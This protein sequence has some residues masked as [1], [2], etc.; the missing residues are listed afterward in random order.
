MKLSP[1]DLNSLCELA[2]KAALSAGSII[3]DASV[4]EIKIHSKI[5]GENIASQVVTE[6][7]IAA[8]DAIVKILK[9]TLKEF[10]LG[11]LTEESEDDNSRFSHDYFWCIDP[12]DGTLAFSQHL[13]GYST[14]IA[15]VSNE[16]KSTI[17]VVY[18]PKANDLYYAI[19]GH[20]AFKND[21]PFKVQRQNDYLTLLFDQSFLKH[22]DYELE[23]KRLETIANKH[24]LRGVKHHHLGGAVMN[25]ISTIEM[26]P[27][28]YYK[29]P[30]TALGGG[31]LWDFAASSFIHSEAGGINTSFENTALNLNPKAS[32]FMNDQG[33]KFASDQIIFNHFLK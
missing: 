28:I 24:G 1:S 18:N 32:T 8:Q 2:K 25:G 30:K 23:I 27:A 20:G 5:G 29:Q 13:D 10:D 26:S 7:D 19:N 22:S 31:S 12:L 11:L 3:K 9:P 4:K 15:L 14:S 6:I 21:A 17:G 33:I 16:G